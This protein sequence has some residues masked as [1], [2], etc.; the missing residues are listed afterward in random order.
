MK[1]GTFFVI[2]CWSILW[3][4]I[5]MNYF[6]ST[7]LGLNNVV[8]FVVQHG[9]EILVILYGITGFVVNYLIIKEEFRLLHLRNKYKQ[10]Q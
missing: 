1:N 9:F 4:L 8:G 3:T 6:S 7:K 10:Q 2:V 5:T